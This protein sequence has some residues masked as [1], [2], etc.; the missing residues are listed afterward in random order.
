M[1]K[2]WTSH[3][4]QGSFDVHQ[5]K[6]L[7]DSF[8]YLLTT[9][10][11]ALAIDPAEPKPILKELERLGLNL[12]AIL[13]TDHHEEH[14]G[15]V[16]LLKKETDCTIVGPKHKEIE[17]L[18]QDV[19]EGDE[20]V[21]GPFVFQV[22]ALPGHTLDLVGY[23]FHECSILFCGDAL[24]FVGCDDLIEG[25][26]EQYFA[27]LQK[28]KQLPPKTILFGGRSLIEEHIKF[29][30]TIDP[31]LVDLNRD[32]NA[33]F[34]TLEEELKINPFLKAASPGELEEL[35]KKC[36]LKFKDN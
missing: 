5:I 22:L 25:T 36:N 29:A 16:R 12:E 30:K 34:Q 11:I 15:G 28:I 33:T 17:D 23:Y 3:F 14:I 4:D 7:E 31:N 1:T 24:F 13:I 19:V 9:D 21:V 10:K 18:D 32:P 8:S 6:L 35:F 20:N 26:A 2:I 27:S